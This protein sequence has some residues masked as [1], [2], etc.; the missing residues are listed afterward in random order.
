[1][2]D[3]FSAV[4]AGLA[5]ILSAFAV[6]RTLNHNRSSVTLDIWKIWI[7]KEYREY[8]VD[9]F[10]AIKAARE[11]RIGDE[12]LQMTAL[13]SDRRTEEAIGSVEH[14][15]AE[16]ASIKR[17]GLMDERLFEALF[18]RS[19]A[20]W[21]SLLAGFARDKTEAF[22]D[23]ELAETFATLLGN[24]KDQRNRFLLPKPDSPKS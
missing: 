12:P 16:L 7:S 14:I 10:R 13:L 24:T 9:A 22:T 2:G 8:R 6:Y 20:D 17:L 23:T 5:C 19:T 1:L 15:F 21:Q 11:N 4:F 18:Y 3:T